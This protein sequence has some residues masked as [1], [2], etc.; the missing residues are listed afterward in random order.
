[1]K[2]YDVKSP[3]TIALGESSNS[4]VVTLLRKYVI[5]KILLRYR[6]L[7]CIRN[8]TI[9][10]GLRKSGNSKYDIKKA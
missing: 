8:K 1:M 10:L 5:I 3:S 6:K 9:V 7:E 2:V 4:V